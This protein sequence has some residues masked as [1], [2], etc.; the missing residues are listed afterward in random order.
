MISLFSPALK[1]IFSFMEELACIACTYS[2]LRPKALQKQFKTSP[3][4]IVKIL[5]QNSPK[6]KYDIFERL[7]RGAVKLNDQEVRNCIY[8]GSYNDL[9]KKLAT[10]KNYMFALGQKGPHKRMQDRELVLRFLAFYHQTYHKYTPPMKR[11]LNIACM[12][13]DA[14]VKAFLKG[15]IVA[16]I[17]KHP[18]LSDI[19]AKVF[20]ILPE[21]TKITRGL[22]V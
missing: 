5:K 10:N 11:F 7:N 16:G 22:V 17:M 13:D 15:E 12:Q 21:H 3:L 6:L 20:D 8:H 18:A 2:K 14:S 9:I 1:D 19:E 4:K